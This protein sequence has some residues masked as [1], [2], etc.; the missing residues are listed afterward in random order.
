[1]LRG[2]GF[3]GMLKSFNGM[4]GGEILPIEYNSGEYKLYAES[5]N[6]MRRIFIAEYINIYV[7]GFQG[8]A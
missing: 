2:W 7:A 1:M 5:I 8:H 4:G 3:K 6:Y